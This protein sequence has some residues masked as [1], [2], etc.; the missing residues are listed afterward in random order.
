M[1]AIQEPE[2][3]PEKI[4]QWYQE[5]SKP[6][7]STSGAGPQP[8]LDGCCVSH[9]PASV[10][11]F[12][13]NGLAYIIPSPATYLQL[14]TDWNGILNLGSNF[15]ELYIGGILSEDSAL[16]RGDARA[17]VYLVCSG[18]SPTPEKHWIP[19]GQQLTTMNFSWQQIQTKPQASVDDIPTGFALSYRANP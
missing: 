4:K 8:V 13:M 12:V 7:A 17:E 18:P 11:Y 6:T 3:Q 16:I 15:A 2:K 1:E 10:V 5:G 19:S 9:S 14:F